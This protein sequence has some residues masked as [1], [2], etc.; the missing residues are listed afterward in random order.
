MVVDADVDLLPPQCR[1]EFEARLKTAQQLRG[2]LSTKVDDS[3]TVAAKKS[4][5]MLSLLNI[6]EV[7]FGPSATRADDKRSD[8]STFSS[9]HRWDDGYEGEET[10]SARPANLS[11][12]GKFSLETPHR[13]TTE[14]SSQQNSLLEEGG[15]GDAPLLINRY[16][17][18]AS[19]IVLA[20]EITLDGLKDDDDESRYIILAFA[21]MR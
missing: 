1:A 3:K 14:S 16:R 20:S 5:S 17:Q 13:A 11:P 15:V 9:C 19:G 2:V 10:I 6:G 8:A 4:A 21:K 18:A 12:R 7:F